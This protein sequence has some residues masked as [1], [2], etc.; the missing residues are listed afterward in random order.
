MEELPLAGLC[1]GGL[2]WMQRVEVQVGEN[3][4]Q[5]PGGAQ[6]TNVSGGY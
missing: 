2:V 5:Q 4:S 6:D 3:V 1:R